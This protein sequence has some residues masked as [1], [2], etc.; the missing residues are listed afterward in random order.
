MTWI[1]Y[2]V[3]YWK[4][5]KWRSSDHLWNN[6]MPQD[7]YEFL[8]YKH[9]RQRLV[10]ILRR[11]KCLV[12]Y[13]MVYHSKATDGAR[14]AEMVRLSMMFEKLGS[15]F[16]DVTRRFFAELVEF[17]EIFCLSNRTHFPSLHIAS[18]KHEEGW[19]NS[20]SPLSVKMRLCIRKHGKSVLI[21][22]YKI[23][24]KNKRKSETSQSFLHTPI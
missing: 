24:L 19:E 14:L 3:C 7:I 20:P 18:S 1:M 15:N 10:C 2:E 4:V 9:K 16:L 21:C 5:T 17:P 11:Y 12:G 23:V 22:V 6:H 13:S 8:R